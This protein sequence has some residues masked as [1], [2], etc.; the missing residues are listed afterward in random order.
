M[1]EFTVEYMVWTLF[2]AI[3]AAI[4]YVF[5][6]QRCQSSLAGKLIEKG[7]D[8]EQNAKTLIE[9]G[10]K[11]AFVMALA[12]FFAKNGSHIAKSIVTVRE[13]EDK[14]NELLFEKNNK[15]KYYIPKEKIDKKLEKHIKDKMS[16]GK[17][18]LVILLLCGLATIGSTVIDLLSNYASSLGNSGNKIIGVETERDSLLEEQEKATAEEERKK[19]EEEELAKIEQQAKE[20]MEAAIEAEKNNKA[21]EEVVADIDEEDDS[22]VKQPQES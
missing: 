5:V 20:E 9:L 3:I 13:G 2:F 14:E 16:L 7:A 18:V 8:K 19:K 12:E 15:V 11:S 10:Y 21:D 17:L 22:S 4:L 1:K 6:M